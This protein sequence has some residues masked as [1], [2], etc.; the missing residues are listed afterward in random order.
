M[1]RPLTRPEI[2]QVVDWAAAEGWN[3]GRDDAAVF[4]QTDPQGFVGLEA[5]GAL[6]ASGSMVSYAGRM[7]FVGLFIV[8]PAFRGQGFGKALW[9]H[10]MQAL[11]ERLD[12]GAPMALDG[13]KAMEDTYAASGFRTAHDDHRMRLVSATA[14]CPV[15]VHRITSAVGSIGEFDARCFGAPRPV[16]LREWLRRPGHIALVSLSDRLRGFGVV[17][18]CRSGYKVGPLFAEDVK[19]ADGLLQGFFSFLPAGSEVFLDVPSSN[20]VALRW[21]EEEL[22]G[23]EVFTCARMYTG[24]APA[25]DW[26]RVFGVTTLELG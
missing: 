11:P 1:I 20:A 18:P 14:D 13:V 7:G 15:D 12:P 25:T 10:M 6:V 22:G 4:W 3:P 26:S 2:D 8:R 16:F 21:A 23:V 17:R 19:V 24:K 5:D 9:E